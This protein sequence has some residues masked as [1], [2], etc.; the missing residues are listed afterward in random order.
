ME[1]KTAPG[2]DCLG[3]VNSK[4]VAILLAEGSALFFIFHTYEGFRGPNFIF[5]QVDCCQIE[6]NSGNISL[7]ATIRTEK[8]CC[9]VVSDMGWG[10]GGGS[11][12]GLSPLQ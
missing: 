7:L 11:G 1:K 2:Y 12:L 10:W 3:G 4:A 8:M 6:L 5:S 9:C